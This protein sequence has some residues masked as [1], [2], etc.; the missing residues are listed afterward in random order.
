MKIN[1]EE[2]EGKFTVCFD[3]YNM[4][5]AVFINE[6][7]FVSENKI[8]EIE[9]LGPNYKHIGE[10][11][12][13]VEQDKIEEYIAAILTYFKNLEIDFGSYLVER[14]EQDRKCAIFL[15]KI[16]G[17]KNLYFS[18]NFAEKS[19]INEKLNYSVKM[20]HSEKK[21]EIFSGNE[22]EIIE[23][24][25]DYIEKLLQKYERSGKNRWK[26][27]RYKNSFILP[28]L[29]AEEFLKGELYNLA[30]EFA[31]IGSEKIAEYKLKNV[32]PQLFINMKNGIDFIGK[33]SYVEIEGEKIG[34]KSAIESFKES[35][36]ILLA[37]G[38]KAMVDSEFMEKIT[39]VFDKKSG[40]KI[41]MFDFPTIYGL[42]EI[43]QDKNFEKLKKIYSGF[44]SISKTENEK[45]KIN[46]ELRDYQ[47]YGHNWL[48]Y[49]YENSFG[50]CLAD[51]MGLGKTVQAI[52]LLSKVYPGKKSSS[53]IVMPKSLVFNWEN[54]IKK[55]AP[56]IKVYTYY[57][58]EREVAL[59]KKADVIITTYGTVRNDIEFLKKI[60]YELVI[61]DEAQSIKN[62][63]SMIF[64][65]IVSLKAK[66]RFALSGTP[67][68]NNIF[69]VYAIFKFLN[70]DMFGTLAEFSRDYAVPIQRDGDRAASEELRSKIYP[71][72]LRRTKKDVL[73]SLPDKIEK[74]MY[75]EMDEKHRE[76]YEERRKYYSTLI[77]KKI[78]ESGI[79]KT[80][81]FVLQALGE[82][83]QIA[84][85]PE[86]KTDGAIISSKQELLVENILDA[87]SNDHRVLIFTNYLSV[88]DNICAKLDEYGIKNLSMTGKSSNRK[89]IVEEFQQNRDYKVLVMTLKTGGVGLNLT[90]ADMVFIY[91]PWWN[92][93]AEMQAVDRAHRMG[94]D[95]TVF[96]YKFITR[97]S[98]E[99]KILM[100]QQKKSELFQDIIKSDG[101]AVKM[102]TG[103]EIEYILG[104]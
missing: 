13:E 56:D 85:A 33:D 54:E 89:E 35:G 96:S 99:E 66:A 64:K 47:V 30:R 98:I 80:R 26:I 29:C 37:D 34:I 71:F 12:K 94:Q 32:K 36:H 38:T 45:I 17:K 61:L 39:R 2:S 31:I 48:T 88:V 82:L 77:K 19:E 101:T 28:E 43:M 87:V 20:E 7:Y 51:D 100:L 6:R 62:V 97:N 63:N 58:Q 92:K 11:A 25:V 53:L 69:E 102:L 93:S 50:G 72:I 24:K 16:D 103:E 27:F 90:S 78:E 49:I 95:K 74:V 4:K 23:E 91:D 3:K 59:A 65:N 52:S 22:W 84:T 1:M 68:E 21:V 8:I 10:L 81:F 40:N 5:T 44:N 15:E 57:G 60:S 18:I 83:R 86:A 41:N 70:P 73:S 104:E 67:V 75:V 46:A 79:S 9:P 55:L 76:F 14:K 42:G